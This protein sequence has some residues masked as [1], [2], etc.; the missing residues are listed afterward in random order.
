MARKHCLDKDEHGKELIT[1]VF[2]VKKAILNILMPEEA[3]GLTKMNRQEV[4]ANFPRENPEK[5]E[6]VKYRRK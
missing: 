1:T 4:S 2:S 6:I 3:T 5:A